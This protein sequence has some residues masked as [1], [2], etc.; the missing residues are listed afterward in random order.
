[1]EGFLR[2]LMADN[3]LLPWMFDAPSRLRLYWSPILCLFECA[4]P[5]APVAILR[6]RL[7]HDRT[8][9]RALATHVMKKY[10]G[11]SR[12]TLIINQDHYIFNA[13]DMGYAYIS[14]CA[15]ARAL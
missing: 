2:R 15:N 14:D 13:V 1:M 6:E 12:H 8:T 10:A 7:A 9:A 4:S 11:Y 3:L 5:L